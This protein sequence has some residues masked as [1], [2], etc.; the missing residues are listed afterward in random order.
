K[1]KITQKLSEDD[2]GRNNEFCDE[3]MCP[4]ADNNNFYD[5]IIFFDEASPQLSGAINRHNCLY[6]G[7]DNPH[8]MCDVRTQYP[9]KLTV[10]SGFCE[11]GIV[12]QFF[13]TGNLNA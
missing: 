4:Y 8:W 5:H 2:F 10:W 12:G 9:Q 6:W 11:R 13:I 7:D 3:K 1:I